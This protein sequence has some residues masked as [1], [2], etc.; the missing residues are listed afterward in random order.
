VVSKARARLAGSKRAVQTFDSERF[1]LRKLNELEASKRFQMKISNRFEAHD[2][3]IG[4]EKINRTWEKS[5]EN[6]KISAKDSLGLYEFK[7]HNLWLDE[8]FLG[9]LDQRKQVKCSSHKIRTEA[10]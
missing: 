2:I 8:G 7:Q 6:I 4:S 3:L 10:M 5:K 9:F 1:N